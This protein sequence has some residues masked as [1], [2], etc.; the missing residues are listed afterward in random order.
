MASSP[1][2]GDQEDGWR[3]RFYRVN[4]VGKY[5]YKYQK[6]FD[7]VS[8]DIGAVRRQ[9]KN[10]FEDCI[11]EDLEYEGES[12]DEDGK[13]WRRACSSWKEKIANWEGKE[14]FTVQTKMDTDVRSCPSAKLVVTPATLEA[15]IVWKHKSKGHQP[16]RASAAKE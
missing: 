15:V 3:V 16:F 9:M 2:A 7:I 14:K 12:E 13:Q 10:F 11:S 5:C 8:A 1:S 6:E 4:E